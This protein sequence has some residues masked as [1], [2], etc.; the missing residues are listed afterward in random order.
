VEALADHDAARHPATAG[1]V[2]DKVASCV[3][4]KKIEHG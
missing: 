1:I 2:V 4:R 3:E